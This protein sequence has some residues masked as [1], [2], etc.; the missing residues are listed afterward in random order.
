MNEHE[1]LNKLS[2]AARGNQPP[3]IDPTARVLREIQRR[4]PQPIRF[5]A[6][7]TATASLA[8]AVLA[9]IG[10]QAWMTLQDP[11]NQMLTL[12]NQVSP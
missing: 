7:I 3:P 2:A 1:L 10:L 8:A 5:A 12:A 6:A 9:A 11:L 4:E